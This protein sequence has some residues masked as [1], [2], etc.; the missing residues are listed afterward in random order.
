MTDSAR[1]RRATLSDVAAAAGVSQ[2]TVSKALNG[3]DDV[4]AETREIVLAAVAELGYR[5]TTAPATSSRRAIAVTF[6][7]PASPYILN[8]L[9]GVL[10]AATENRLDLLTRLPPDR[11]ARGQRAVGRDWIAEQRA[12]GAIGVVGLTLSHPDALLD[13]AS[14]AGLPFVMVDPVDATHKRLVSVASSNWAGART[15]ADYLIGLGHR[16]IAW[17]GGPE[18]SAAARDR[19]YG[20]RAALDAAGL[21]IDPAHVVADQ[22]DAAAGARH[23]RAMLGMDLPPTAIMAADDEI[24]VGVLAAAR[25]LG[26]SVPR[27]LSVIGFDDTPQAS[28]TTPPLTTVH[29]HL[30]EMGRMAVHTVV[31]IAEGRRPVSRHVELATSLTIRETTAPPPA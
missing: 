27:D 22:F 1:R 7:I 17:I 13:A 16:R 29:Q 15:A 5:P 8:V 10:V 24:A 21:E 9:Q 4:A 31:A 19:L 3:R 26:V 23:A 30:D 14:E 25:E 6:D 2:A 12:S 11:A 28:W 20:Y 18:A